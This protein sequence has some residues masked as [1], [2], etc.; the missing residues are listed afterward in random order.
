[1]LLG[2]GLFLVLVV[3]GSYLICASDLIQERSG[4]QAQCV[5]NIYKLHG[6]QPP[7]SELVAGH[8]L[9]MEPERLSK[10]GLGQAD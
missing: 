3:L 7:L 8:E 4:L 5:G 9:L 6:V 2:C 1:M 10:C